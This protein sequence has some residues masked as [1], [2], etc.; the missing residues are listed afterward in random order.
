MEILLV[1]LLVNYYT[2]NQLI[3]FH[4]QNTGI[5]PLSPCRVI[6]TAAQVFVLLDV[7]MWSEVHGSR[8]SASKL[9]FI[10]LY[11]FGEI[12]VTSMI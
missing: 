12:D 3:Q 6:F 5:S 1:P 8:L 7:T 9:I 2:N 11:I 4:L 10:F